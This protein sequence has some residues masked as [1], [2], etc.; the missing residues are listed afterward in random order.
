M[1]SAM[2]SA[3]EPAPATMVMVTHQLHPQG[4]APVAHNSI[5]PAEQ[6]ALQGIPDAP[7][8][9]RLGTGDQHAMVLSHP[10]KRL[11]FHQRIHLCMGSAD[12]YLGA[13]ATT[14]AR[15]AKLMP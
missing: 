14:L 10:H 4:T 1:Q 13:T 9:T 3:K 7:N 12:A 2:T 8:A 15:V 11:H 6:T 5:Q